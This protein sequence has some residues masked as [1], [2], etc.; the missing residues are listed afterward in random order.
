MLSDYIVALNPVYIVDYDDALGVDCDQT[1]GDMALFTVPFKCKVH[2]AQVCVTED[3]AGATTVPILKYDK[4][5]AA[6]SD[7]GRGDGDVAVINLTV[8]HDAGAVVFDEAGQNDLLYPGQEVVVQMTQNASGTGAAGHFRPELL[9]KPIAETA[10]N[11]S[12]L[13]ETT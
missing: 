10:A 12:A 5:A 3:V 13:T 6:G 8:A 1:A 9:V 2:R 11:L 7:T 4:R